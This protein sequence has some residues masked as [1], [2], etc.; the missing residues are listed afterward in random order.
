MTN[1]I[2]ALNKGKS[3]IILPLQG[4]SRVHHIPKALLRD[5]VLAR[6]RK[7]AFFVLA[8]HNVALVYRVFGLSGRGVLK[9]RYPINPTL[10]VWGWV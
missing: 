9:V 5:V 8:M 4:G 6:Q 10:A 2:V 1:N 7:W 3:V